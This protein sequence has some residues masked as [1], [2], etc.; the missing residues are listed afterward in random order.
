MKFNT[1]VPSTKT[2]NLAGGEAF[3][4]TPKL[5]LVSLMLTSFV[6]DQFYRSESKS[7]KDLNDLVDKISDKKFVAKAA[8]YART[9]FGMRSISHVCAGEIAKRVKGEVWLKNFFD[10]I[11]YRPDDMMEIRAYLGKDK[12]THAMQKGFSK[13][14]ARFN[15]YELA[16]YKKTKANISLV[17]VVNIAH[18]KNTEAIDKLMKGTLSVPETWEAKLTQAGQKAGSDEE[19]EEMKK[20]VWS[21]LIKERKIG[22]FAL[23]RNLRNIIEQAPDLVDEAVELLTDEKLIHK[24]LVLPF[25]FSTAIEEI[26]KLNGKEAQK[27]MVGLNVALDKATANV[28]KFD[29][30]TLVALDCSGSMEGKP[31][32][33]GSLF[34]AVL[35]KSNNA[36]LMVF[37]DNA[38]YKTINPSDS[39]LTIAKS[40]RFASG[41]TNFHAILQEANQAYDRIII[42]SD[43]QGWVGYMAPTKTFAEYKKRLGANPKIYSFDLSGYG[44]LQFPENDVYCV[45]GFSEKVFDMMKLL[46]EDR[47]ALVNEIERVEL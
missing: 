46:E 7:L 24:S 4:E 15:E 22:Y 1:N 33:I 19:K 44:S 30:N 12:I 45:A 16:K 28:P 39:T 23:L 13:A 11:I 31:A 36:D 41:G 32:Q 9:K 8:I 35:V 27:V 10:K 6:K 17:D 42:L 26:E 40:L 34:A 18:P 2:E 29:G 25:R 3:Q 14:L 21:Q 47:H 38:E 37:D 20:E 5:A 43:M